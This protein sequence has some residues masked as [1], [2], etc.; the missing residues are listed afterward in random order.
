MKKLMVAVL[1][2]AVALA[3]F[4]YP[5]YLEIGKSAEFTDVVRTESYKMWSG[6]DLHSLTNFTCYFG[7]GSVTDKGFTNGYFYRWTSEQDLEVQFQ[8]ADG[9]LKSVAVRFSQVG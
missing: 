4:G 6:V 2:G 5:T 8:K 3:S 7:G 1:A 9:Y